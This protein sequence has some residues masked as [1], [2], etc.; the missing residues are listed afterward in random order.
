MNLT[1]RRLGVD[2]ITVL[3]E[4][5]QQ[6]YELL[7]NSYDNTRTTRMLTKF[8]DHHPE[9][10]DAN[11]MLAIIENTPSASTRKELTKQLGK[12]PVEKV[13]SFLENL[14][15]DLAL[16][17]RC[18]AEDSL[19]SHGQGFGLETNSDSFQSPGWQ[20]LLKDYG[21]Y[22]P[23]SH[24]L[25]LDMIGSQFSRSWNLLSEDSDSFPHSRDLVA[26]FQSIHISFF[27]DLLK[28]MT[29][30][31]LRIP[32][33]LSMRTSYMNVGVRL[34]NLFYLAYLSINSNPFKQELLTEVKQ[35]MVKLDEVEFP[36]TGQFRK[37]EFDEMRSQG[38]N[39]VEL[40]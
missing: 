29:S 39:L 31:K 37:N 6:I 7:Q 18:S 26:L 21:D 11:E 36:E 20:N 16:D 1:Y 30:I 2:E 32:K 8:L 15:F 33:L 38:R 14:I 17:V 23:N 40:L 12:Y 5:R 28:V 9:P 35:I 19:N 22:L 10:H 3:I 13:K 27:E 34:E 4:S 25:L 24:H